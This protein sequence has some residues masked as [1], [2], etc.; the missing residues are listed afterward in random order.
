MWYPSDGEADI[1]NINNKAGFK[2]LMW[3]RRNL[4]HFFAR[5]FQKEIDEEFLRTVKTYR[6]SG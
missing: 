3:N 6:I 5:F 4:Y 2:Q 1:M